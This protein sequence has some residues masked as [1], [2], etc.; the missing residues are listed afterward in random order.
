LVAQEASAAGLT[1][2]GSGFDGRSDVVLLRADPRSRSTALELRTTEDVFVEV[3]RATRT[4]REDPRELARQV[5]NP[6]AVQRALSVWADE[7]RPLASSMTFRVIVRV[8]H[9]RSFLRTDLRR[10][11]TGVVGA[12]RPKWRHAD[13][14][15]IEVWMSEYKP[16][17]FVA[18]LRLTSARMRQH[19]GRRIERPGALRPTVAAAMVNQAG[20]PS[21]ALLDPCCGSGSILTEAIARGWTALGRDIDPAAVEIARTNAPTATVDPGDARAL[22]LPDEGV[23]ACVS[24][25]PFGRQYAV[26]GSR[27]DWLKDALEE[28]ARVT[29]LGGR[30]V[31]LMPEISR[32]AIPGSLRLTS[33]TPIQLLGT[34]TSIWALDR[35][36]AS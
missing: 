15:Q 34:K 13:P 7:V 12:D 30:V 4:D 8:L 3:G 32:S 28:L 16:D 9:E 31:L 11:L 24:N 2:T 26:P 1:H 10:A 17:E 33:R 36:W 22:D 35:R 19:D 27:T 14:A 25:L 23:A 21:G 5:W 18:G 29:R 6:D 20:E